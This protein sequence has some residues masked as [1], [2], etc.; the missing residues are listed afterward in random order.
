MSTQQEYWDACLIRTWRKAG[1]VADAV[2][3]FFSITNK[4]L[5]ECDPALLRIPKEGFPWKIGIRVFVSN[6]LSKISKRLWDQP[7][8]R[9]IALLQKLK[10]SR[11]DTEE[12]NIVD[13][14]H[15]TEIRK[16]HRNQASQSLTTHLIS[17]RNHGTNW[18]VVKGPRK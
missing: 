7:P 4:K 9:D 18:N 10:S 3:M 2:R 8:E 6:H 11:Y 17:E 1:T 15:R 13:S 12:N 5:H 14:A 16:L